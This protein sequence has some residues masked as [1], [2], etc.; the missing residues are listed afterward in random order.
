MVRAMMLDRGIPFRPDPRAANTLAMRSLTRG[1]IAVASRL[2]ENDSNGG[3]ASTDLILKRRNWADDRLAGMWATRAT[4]SPAM[5]TTAGWAAELAQMTQALLAHLTPQS[6][7]AQFL[8][9]GHSLS[10]DGA[11][12]IMVPSL[13]GGA[14]AWISENTAIRVVNFLSSAPQL[15]PHK[16]AASSVLTQ[17]MIAGSNAEE[18][19]KTALVDACASAIDTALFSATAGSAAQPAGLLVGATGVAAS[20]STDKLDAMGDDLGALAAAVAP[21]AGNGSIMYAAAPQQAVRARL[22]TNSPYPVLMSSALAAGSVICVATNALAS[23]VE[24]PE[25]AVGYD[26]SLHLDDTNP[27]TPTSSPSKSMYQSGGVALKMRLPITW[28]TRNAAA[29]AYLTG[30]TKW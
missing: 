30:S 19:V 1:V 18:L 14:A 16:L 9:N 23:V 5:T 22:Y 10:F 15:Q 4:T 3:K 28:I 2:F 11:A 13:S 6:A 12:T 24:V 8:A 25:I 7:G 29:V 20:A 27:Q 21:Y 17:E 26:A